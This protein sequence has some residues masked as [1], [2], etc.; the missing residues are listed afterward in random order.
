MIA[1]LKL[2]DLKLAEDIGIEKFGTAIVLEIQFLLIDRVK[3]LF[4]R[5]FTR[6]RLTAAIK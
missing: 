5:F 4:R 6:S 3:P 1:R 2:A